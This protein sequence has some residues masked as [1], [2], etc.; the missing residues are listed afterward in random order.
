MVFQNQKKLTVRSAEKIFLLSL[1]SHGYLIVK[2]IIEVIELKKRNIKTKN[3]VM[4]AFVRF[5]MIKKLIGKQFR[6]LKN[7]CYFGF[8]YIAVAFSSLEKGG[9]FSFLFTR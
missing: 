1:L 9:D 5:I 7:A 4:T 6:V 8:I 3:G 2:R